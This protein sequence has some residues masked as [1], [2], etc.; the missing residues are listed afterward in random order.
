M[1]TTSAT[2]SEPARPAAHSGGRPDPDGVNEADLLADE[3][4]GVMASFNEFFRGNEA[5]LE[6][7]LREVFRSGSVQGVL[8]ATPGYVTGKYLAM[9]I[10]SE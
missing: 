1:P 8:E 6:R 5:S 2:P 9:A 10:K 4:P 3:S 7:D